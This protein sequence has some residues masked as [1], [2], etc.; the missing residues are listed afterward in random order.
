MTDY[1]QTEYKRIKE[2]VEMCDTVYLVSILEEHGIMIDGEDR[3]ETVHI[4][5]RRIMMDE[6]DEIE[7]ITCIGV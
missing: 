7:V 4:M 6:V 5:T 3:A 1:E 2:T